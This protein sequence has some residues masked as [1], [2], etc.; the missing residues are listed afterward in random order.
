MRGEAR[1]RRRGKIKRQ[2]AKIKRQKWR[3]AFGGL[4]C[5]R[6]VQIDSQHHRKAHRRAR[7]PWGRATE[8]ADFVLNGHKIHLLA[9]SDWPTR[10]A[11]SRAEIRRLWEGVKAAGVVALPVLGGLHHDYRR[12]A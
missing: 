10:A 11:R 9:S 7:G 6:A 12:A 3:C 1:G 5:R 2:K 4:H 8:G